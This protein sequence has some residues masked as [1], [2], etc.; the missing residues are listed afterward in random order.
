MGSNPTLSTVSKKGVEVNLLENISST[1]D[2]SFER[3]CQT[4][5]RRTHHYHNNMYIPTSI[6]SNL[7]FVIKTE[8][9]V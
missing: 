9:W 7:Q 6:L 3:D 5:S 8:R 4:V 2:P 1:L